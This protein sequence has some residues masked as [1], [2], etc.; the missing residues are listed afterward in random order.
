[1]SLSSH[2][3]AQLR[4]VGDRIIEGRA[5]RYDAMLLED[6]AGRHEELTECRASR[7][8]TKATAPTPSTG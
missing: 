8:S 5:D 2:E 4:A 1:M 7:R 6:I 3:A